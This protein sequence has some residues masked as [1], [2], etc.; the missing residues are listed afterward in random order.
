MNTHLTTADIERIRADFPLLQQREHGHPLVYLDNSN[1]TQKPRSVLQA[2]DHY[3]QHNNANVHRSVYALS[4]RAT[5]DYEGARD[6]IQQLIHAQH[7]HEIIFVKGATEG[8]NL[9]ANSFARAYVKAGD[10]IIISAMEHHAN[11]VPWQWVCEQYGATL[12]V[13]PIHDN[14]ELDL[15]AYHE[16]INSRT[17]LVAITHVSNVLGTINPVEK[18]IA[19]AHDNNIPVLLDG[20][21]ALPHLTVD[22]QAL[23]C[24]F[25]IFSGH[26]MYGPTGTGVVYGKTKWLEEMPPYQGG[27]SMI[28]QVTFAKSTYQKLP[29][30]FEAGTPNIAGIIGLGAAADY[31]Q[32]LDLTTISVYEQRLLE[33]ATAQLQAIP[34]V[35]I[36]GTAPEK[37]AIISFVM[38]DIHPH[39][40]GTVLDSRGLAVRVGHHCAM[41]LMD[42]YQVPA[43]V[44]VSFAPYNTES[45]IVALA[46]ALRETQRMFHV[47][48]D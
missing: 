33:Q 40:I 12:R 36:I 9:I 14:G 6:K 25:Y 44:R 43:T 39:D 26:K 13:I 38:T 15:Q 48:L 18:I 31:L 21:Q 42:R 11:I 10:E 7:R 35:R 8:I 2:M 34:G 16:L 37:A 22:V 29:Y 28:Q 5:Q 24:D 19:R 45:D 20:A 27:G 41:P 47:C 4:E 30:K 23:D 32:Q 3:Y 17:R 1:T 46:E